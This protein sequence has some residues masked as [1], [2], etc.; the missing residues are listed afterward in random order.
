[1]AS[2]M[3]GS[4]KDVLVSFDEMVQW[5]G[6][7]VEAAGVIV[8]VVGIGLAT[9]QYLRRYQ[10]QSTPPPYTLYRRSLGRAILLGLEFLLAGDIIRTVATE[11]TFRTMG[12]LAIVV[13]IRTFLS[14]ELEMELEGH[15]P[16]QREKGRSVPSPGD[17]ETM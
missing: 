7:V 12:L 10:E 8:I 1:M 14:V 11:P 9:I 4:W 16:W 3:P 17:V 5:S 6:K 13:A 2:S 15:W